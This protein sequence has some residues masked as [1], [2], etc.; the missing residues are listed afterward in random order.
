M[1][2]L[3][4]I[5]IKF[6]P[7]DKFDTVVNYSHI[8]QYLILYYHCAVLTKFHHLDHINNSLLRSKPVKCYITQ[9][10][11]GTLNMKFQFGFQQT[12]RRT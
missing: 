5:Y 2:K 7:E 10:I 6:T 8:R 12:K 9:Y 11:K 3:C 4:K 1:K